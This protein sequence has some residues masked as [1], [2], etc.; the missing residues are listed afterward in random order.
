MPETGEITKVNIGLPRGGICTGLDR[1]GGG[2]SSVDQL[3]NQISTVTGDSI[4][5][6][7]NQITELTDIVNNIET[8]AGG[9]QIWGCYYTGSAYSIFGSGTTGIA[10]TGEFVSDANFDWITFHSGDN[11]P[12]EVTQDGWYYI[13]YSVYLQGNN[14]SGNDG[15]V[16]CQL[17]LDTGSGNTP[18]ADSLAACYVAD[19][20]NSSADNFTVQKSILLEL[21]AGTL[22]GVQPFRGGANKIW[23][24]ANFGTNDITGSHTHIFIERCNTHIA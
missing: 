9:A 6:L 1:L 20:N 4:I 17:V 12:A 14:N 16:S 7:Q 8:G 3:L 19:A 21:T 10:M 18:N 11:K 24:A 2:G 23:G 22:I 5:N 15:E 13:T